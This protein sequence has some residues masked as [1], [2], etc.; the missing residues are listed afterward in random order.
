MWTVADLAAQ[1]V[2]AITYGIYPTASISEV[3]YHVEHGGAVLFIAED[4]EYVDKI[5]PLVDELPNLRGVVVIDTTAMFVYDHPKIIAYEDVLKMGSAAAE[6]SDALEALVRLLEPED[7]AF[8]V[9]TSGTTGNPKGAVITH[10][11]HLAATY[12][13]LIH[14]PTLARDPHRTVAFLPLGHVI[15]R[16]SAITIPLLSKMVPHYGESVDDRADTLF[17]VAPTFLFTVPRYLQKFASSA[18]IGIENT[19]PLKR[20]LYRLAF[21]YGRQH[22]QNRWAGHGGAGEHAIYR[23]AHF[24]LFRPILNKLGFDQLR[25]VICGGAALGREL[26]GLWQ[27]WD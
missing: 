22:R 10:G 25:L 12:T 15:G 16:I 7:A 20:A 1:A 5:F 26:S 3:R 24:L 9:Y 4:Q 21:A 19:S 6:R 8:I 23:L 13:F 14:Y 11:S 17:E 2:G 27:Y 18:L